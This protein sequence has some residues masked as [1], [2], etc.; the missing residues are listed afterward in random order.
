MFINFI[1]LISEIA[2]ADTYLNLRFLQGIKACA[3]YLSNRLPSHSFSIEQSFCLTITDKV[4][5]LYQLIIHVRIYSKIHSYYGRSAS[6]NSCLSLRWL[7][8]LLSLFVMLYWHFTHFFH[9]LISDSSLT[10]KHSLSN[11]WNLDKGMF[12]QSSLLSQSN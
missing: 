2:I 5:F 7:T 8:M 9:I 12:L 3:S 11:Y 1:N 6:V 10:L 4:I